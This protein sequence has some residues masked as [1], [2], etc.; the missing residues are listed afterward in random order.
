MIEGAEK[1]SA[2]SDDNLSSSDR[3]IGLIKAKHQGFI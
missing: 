3:L 1:F 2:K